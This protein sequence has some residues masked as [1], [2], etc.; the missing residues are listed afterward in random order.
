MADSHSIPSSTVRQAKSAGL[1]LMLL[2]VVMRVRH[3]AE[4]LDRASERA[5]R[6][7]RALADDLR[8]AAAHLES[9]TKELWRLAQVRRNRLERRLQK[10]MAERAAEQCRRDI[11]TFAMRLTVSDDGVG[12]LQIAATYSES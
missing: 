6:R 3:T 12:G 1:G 4:W 10:E 11:D 8:A 2:A 9:S 5:A 7:D